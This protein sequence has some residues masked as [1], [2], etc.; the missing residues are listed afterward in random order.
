LTI[1]GDEATVTTRCS[2]SGTR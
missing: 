2:P 1:G